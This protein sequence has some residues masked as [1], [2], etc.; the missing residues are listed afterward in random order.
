MPMKK[1]TAL[2][3]LVTAGAAVAMLALV[4]IAAVGGPGIDPNKLPDLRSDAPEAVQMP[5]ISPEGRL[6][7]RFNGYVTNVGNG[8]LH[9]QGNPQLPSS[10]PLGPQ[11]WAFLPSQYA[12]TPQLGAGGW[13]IARPAEVVSEGNDDHD[14]F[15]YLRISRYSLWNLAKTAQVAPAEKVGFCLFD[16]E[17]AAG[18]S[19]PPIGDNGA[20]YSGGGDLCRRGQP[21][22]TTLQMGVSPGWRDV[23]DWTVDHQWVDISET[24]P[25]QYYVA[26]EADPEDRVLES[27]E[28]NNGIAFTPEPVTV[29]GYVAAPVGPLGT[30]AGQAIGVELGASAFSHPIGGIGARAFRVTTPPANGTLN[31]TVGQL[32]TN[33]VVTYVPNPG[34][35]GVDTFEYEAR[36]LTSAYPLNSQRAS[37][38]INVGAIPSITVVISGAPASLVVGTSAK[39]T[40]TVTNGS[41][42]VNWSVNGRVGG[43]AKVGTI[44]SGG[45]YKAPKSIPAGGKVTVTA[46]SKENSAKSA[47]KTIKIIAA[48]KLKPS[49]ARGGIMAEPLVTVGKGTVRVRNLAKKAGRFTVGFSYRGKRFA[50]RSRTVKAGRVYIAGAKFPKRWNRKRIRVAVAFKPASGKATVKVAGPTFLSKIKSTRKGRIITARTRTLRTGRVLMVVSHGKTVLRRCQVS[51]LARGTATCRATLRAGMKLSNVRVTA[52][53][54]SEDGLRAVRRG[55]V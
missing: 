53:L 28:S 49:F 15:H 9:I 17:N 14:H 3:L 34:F 55:R 19:N 39:L 40:A 12:D 54:T 31:V 42:G 7:L 10:D 11:Q 23:Y 21:G 27:N 43:N 48:R 20:G 5:E 32:F 29:P 52:R 33:P 46:T 44:G 8:P 13:E 2:S 25:G 16:S 4:P 38:V 47:S 41:G 37:A 51:R 36:D 1:R 35:S 45:L 50:R 24:A 30:P 26:A 6:L 18:F 22:A